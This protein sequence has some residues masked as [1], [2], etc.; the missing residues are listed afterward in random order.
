M[1]NRPPC[2]ADFFPD[3]FVPAADSLTGESCAGGPVVRLADSPDQYSG[4]A[5]E[6]G[7]PAGFLSTGLSAEVSGPDKT[8]VWFAAVP[9]EEVSRMGERPG[10]KIFPRRR[11][12]PERNSGSIP[13]EAAS[14]AVPF[15]KVSF[16]ADE[17]E[18]EE[19]G[20][21]S[22]ISSRALGRVEV[23]N[24]K[25]PPV[26]MKM[27]SGMYSTPLT[28]AEAEKSVDDRS[29][30]RRVGKECRSRWSPYH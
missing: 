26:R 4:R 11:P 24:S 20:L 13:D 25:A 14:K 12:F 19:E 29:E 22:T 23:E 5:E 3:G 7:S 6:D 21:N 28:K 30:E 27:A 9:C 1:T 18:S 2:E 15:C 16:R 17:A 10:Q 8:A